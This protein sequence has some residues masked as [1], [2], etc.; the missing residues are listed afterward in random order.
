MVASLVGAYLVTKH[1]KGELKSTNRTTSILKFYWILC[2]NCV[3][4]ASVISIIYWTMLYREGH[5]NLNNY[6]VHATNSL[7]LIIDLFIVRHPPRMSLFII[8]MTCGSL[9]MFFT[10][11]YT[12][13][14]GVDRD[15]NNFV[16]PILDWKN[17]PEKATVV[18]VGCVTFLGIIHFTVCGVHRLREMIYTC[19]DSETSGKIALPLV[20]EKL[21]K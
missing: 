3:V 17:R 8:P 5:Q 10:V 16:Y 18:G 4:F 7:V 12:Y 6:L 13:L 2:N 14:G 9:Y 19:L 11:V 20:D 1:H 21:P 15:G